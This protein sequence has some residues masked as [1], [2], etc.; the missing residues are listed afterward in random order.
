VTPGEAFPPPPATE[1]TMKQ[2]LAGNEAIARAALEAGVRV[3]AAYPGTP[4]TEILETIATYPGI[5][6]EWAPNEKVALEVALGAAMAGARALA[7]MKHVGLNVAADPLLT[8]SY[9]GTAAGLVVISADDPGMHSSQNEQD[10]RH[11]ARLA[12]IP[13]LEPA[14][15]QE[16][17]DFTR[18]AFEISERFDTPV[19]VR[20]TTRINHG[21][22]PV[23][24]G[25]PVTPPAPAFRRD[26]P[27][28]VMVPAHARRRHVVVEQRALALREF[29][30]TT[31]LNRIEW[32]DR[33]LGI[34]TSGVSYQYVKEA[35]PQASVLKLGFTWPLPP[36]LIRSFAQEVKRLVVVEELDP[37]LEE[38]VAALGFTVEGKSLFPILGELEPSQVAAALAGRQP[39]PPPEL[40]ELPGRPPVLCPGCSHRACFH[41]FKKLKLIAMGDI[42]CYTLS[43]L[44]PLAAIDSCVCMGASVGGAHGVSKALGPAARVIGVLG[45]ST[46]VHSGI[47]PLIDMVYNQGTATVVILDN[48]TT[49]M[50][51]RQ[52]HPA[53]GRTIRGEPTTRLDLEQLCRAVGVKDVQVVDP[54]DV[55]AFEAAMASA[56]ERQEPS[57]VIARHPCL[58][59]TRERGQPL[60][61]DAAA[62]VECGQCFQIGCPAIGVTEGRR[63]P[64][65]VISAELC[66]GCRLCAY[67]CAKG[68]IGVKSGE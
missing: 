2:L 1:V 52:D 55:P 59:L 6:A 47:T 40:P 10:N 30:E 22:S 44:P 9:T 15:S 63:R 5:F 60:V 7:A 45:D 11:Y 8:A 39:P 34:I 65:P 66:T 46:F 42:G 54:G 24:L 17:L 21:K 38:Q 31:P 29:S 56:V 20:T 33:S 53:T 68:A 13:M 27:K 4:S 51:G 61:V 57:V 43:V 25:E 50:T 49:A 36:Q 41:V 12:K 58:L 62:C 32:A 16:C 18:Q 48:G 35:A 3:A 64:Q 37:Y 26:L 14:D 23:T 19:L 67:V 28:Y